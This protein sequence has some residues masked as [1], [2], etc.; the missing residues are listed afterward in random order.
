MCKMAIMGCELCG[1][2]TK[3]IYFNCVKVC[4]EC[5]LKLKKYEK[6]RNISQDKRVHRR[7]S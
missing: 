3:N 7:A 5:Y 2:L 1:K 4:N 6:L